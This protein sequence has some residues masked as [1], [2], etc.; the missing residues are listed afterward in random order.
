MGEETEEGLSLMAEGRAPRLWE[1]WAER[2]KEGRTSDTSCVPGFGLD[3]DS[4]STNEVPLQA[5]E[6]SQ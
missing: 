3:L 5:S 4:T 2:D 6:S 1:N